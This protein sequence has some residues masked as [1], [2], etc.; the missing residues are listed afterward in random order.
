MLVDSCHIRNRPRWP[1]KPKHVS[2][3]HCL[4]QFNVYTSVLKS[5]LTTQGEWAG[6]K[7][8]A[9]TPKSLFEQESKESNTSRFWMILTP[10]E[11]TDFPPE[12]ESCFSSQKPKADP[13][14]GTAEFRHRRNGSTYGSTGFGWPFRLLH[15]LIV[16]KPLIQ[17]QTRPHRWRPSETPGTVE[18]LHA[19]ENGATV[20]GGNHQRMRKETAGCWFKVS[21]SLKKMNVNGDYHHGMEIMENKTIQ[22]LKIC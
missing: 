17:S 21:T 18:P 3:K 7:T 12:V 4:C 2:S 9:S 19:S 11:A 13:R 5:N 10:R 14:D 1:N 20:S 6:L 15:A 8:S 16:V 22:Y